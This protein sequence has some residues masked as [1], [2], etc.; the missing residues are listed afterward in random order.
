MSGLGSAIK[1]G[2]QGYRQAEADNRAYRDEAYQ[3]QQRI[4]E[5]TYTDKMRG[6]QDQQ[7]DMQQQEANRLNALRQTVSEYSN[8]MRTGDSSGLLKVIQQNESPTGANAVNVSVNPDGS[9]NWEFDDGTTQNFN[10]QQFVE[11]LKQ[12]FSPE[13]WLDEQGQKSKLQ[14]QYNHEKNMVGVRANATKDINQS[15]VQNQKDVAKYQNGLK[16][17]TKIEYTDENGL[18]YTRL[19]DSK[20]T[21]EEQGGYED[22]TI[23][24]ANKK[25]SGRGGNGVTELQAAKFFQSFA[26]KAYA[27]EGNGGIMIPEGSR[28]TSANLGELA[29]YIYR[30]DQ[31]ITLNAAA[32]K[33]LRFVETVPVLSVKDA[34][35]K[36]DDEGIGSPGWFASKREENNYNNRVQSMVEESRNPL[37]FKNN[38][39]QNKSSKITIPQQARESGEGLYADMKKNFPNAN[40]DEIRKEVSKR[41]PGWPGSKKK[42]E[43]TT[44]G[45]QDIVRKNPNKK[46]K[47]NGNSNGV[48]QSES[49]FTLGAKRKIKDLQKQLDKARKSSGRSNKARINQLKDQ[50][51]AQQQ[52]LGW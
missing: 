25:G 33:A 3:N 4:D 2:I 8:S 40:D 37:G 34:K 45:V 43:S 50:I 20:D 13:S 24:K 29:N 16:A 11:L 12:K 21:Y 27:S 51:K 46:P 44:M 41:F 15:N 6:R 18:K 42:P 38:Q 14:Q 47:S 22:P 19:Y 1:N 31:N 49:V 7:W 48:S 10:K 52:I 9:T 5:K 17:P 28:I 36:L 26:T 32:A 39:Q 23:T 35:N 30:N